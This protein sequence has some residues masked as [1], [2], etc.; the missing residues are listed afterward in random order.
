V[1]PRPK[2]ICQV[3]HSLDVGGAELLAVRIARQHR[4][5]QRFVFV[6]LDHPGTMAEE[7]L[8]EGFPVHALHRRPGLDGQVILALAAVLR[9]ER[10]DLIQAHQYTPFLYS[11]VARRLWRRPSILFTEHGRLFPDY[12]RP[13]RVWANRL[14]LE[15][16]DRV[17][18]VGEA[19]RQ[20]LF[21]NEGIPKER[22]TV[23]Y[24]GTDTQAH[25]ASVPDQKSLRAEI[26]VGPR[27]LLILQVARLDPIKD[28]AT[29]LRT[30]EHV[31]W[32]RRDARLVLVGEGPE[33]TS[34]ERIVQE[35][36]LAPYVRLLGLRT[37][38]PRLMQSANVFLLT[39][40]SE[41]IPLTV[42][43]A[44]AS[45]LPIVATRVGGLAELVDDG[46]TGILVPAGDDAAL[47]DAILRLARDP[48]LC[49]QMG[50]LGRDRANRFF[51]ESQMHA[52]YHHL[53]EEMLHG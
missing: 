16:R 43:E 19:V 6:C 10:V 39:S 22:V 37:D 18:A 53:Y 36:N 28:H 33:R 30:L 5:S 46:L 29:G 12:R 27:D 15:R 31:V 52:H 13:K 9:R 2:T 24:N 48:P 17:V 49:Q 8:A 4:G 32:H 44:M 40:V 47:A 50:Q 26:R 45:G 21:M 11:L 41:G 35:R 14:L 1:P 3:L 38:I 20:A 34:I 25:A 51:S 7:L 23:I 42:I